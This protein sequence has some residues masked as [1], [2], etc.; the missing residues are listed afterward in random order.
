MD[1]TF[2]EQV[3]VLTAT[4]QSSKYSTSPT[5]SWTSPSRRSVSKVLV[6]AGVTEETPTLGTPYRLTDELTA[7]F[8][9][10]DPITATDRVEVKTG[11]YKGT[12][13][14]NGRPAHWKTPWSGWE[15]G[16]EVRL[17]EVSGG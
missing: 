1:F 16:T 7:I 14:V 2:A 6:Y 15:A 9:Y 3:D 4:L 12:Y 17:K 8:P 13:S 10:G 5:P 11:P